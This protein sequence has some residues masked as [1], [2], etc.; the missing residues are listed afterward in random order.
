MLSAVGLKWLLMGLLTLLS[1]SFYKIIR[2]R[3]DTYDRSK[4]LK[5]K[6]VRNKHVRSVKEAEML[7][8]EALDNLSPS[9]TLSLD[10]DKENSSSHQFTSYFSLLRLLLRHSRMAFYA[11]DD[12][13]A[14]LATLKR[15]DKDGYKTA[16]A[17]AIALQTSLT[18]RFIVIM[19]RHYAGSQARHFLMTCHKKFMRDVGKRNLVVGRVSQDLDCVDI[20]DP[21][22][23]EHI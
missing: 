8:G 5:G 10:N 21:D 14:R 19:D 23:T 1:Y 12:T 15:N 3:A 7:F 2:Y 18:E 13:R 4:K 11:E 6:W 22:R 17:K 9:L 16:V 20:S